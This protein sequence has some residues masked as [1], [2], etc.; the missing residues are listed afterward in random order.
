V[1]TG[2]RLH[3]V[4]DSQVE[5]ETEGVAM[6]CQGGGYGECVRVNRYTMSKQ[7]GQAENGM[8]AAGQA[9]PGCPPRR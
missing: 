6:P 4:A 7:S 9:L 8:V 3:D 5:L 1:R 2:I